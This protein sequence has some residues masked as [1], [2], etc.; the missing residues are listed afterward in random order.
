MLRFKSV[1]ESSPTVSVKISFHLSNGHTFASAWGV[2]RF[3]MDMSLVVSRFIMGFYIKYLC[4][5]KIG[6]FKNIDI[7]KC[8]ILMFDV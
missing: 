4:M 7:K 1:K 8:D 3:S 6:S 5:N 2:I